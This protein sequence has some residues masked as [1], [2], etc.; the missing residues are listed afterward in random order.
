MAQRL[1]S[2]GSLVGLQAPLLT[3]VSDAVEVALQ[4]EEVDAAR[5]VPGNPVTLTVGAFREFPFAGRVASISPTGDPRQRAFTVRVRPDDHGGRLKPGMFVQGTLVLDERGDVPVVQ[6]DALVRADAQ[7]AVFVVGADNRAEL[8][9]VQ[10]G[11]STER[12]AEVAGGLQVGEAVVVVGA[13]A[14]RHGQAVAPS[15]LPAALA[16]RAL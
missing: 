12:L 11:L 8:R 2:A 4:V 1:A 3:L 9:P 6:R 10:L 14:L 13:G 16:G 5:V 7:D 15:P